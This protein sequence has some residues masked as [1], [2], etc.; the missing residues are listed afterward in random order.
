MTSDVSQSIRTLG[1]LAAGVCALALIAMTVAA[2]TRLRGGDESAA[3]AGKIGTVETSL[4]L[5]DAEA[6]AHTETATFALG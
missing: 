2:C 6:P 4:P 3:V 5:I 1:P